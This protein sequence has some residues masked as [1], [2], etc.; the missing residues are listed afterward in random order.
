[1]LFSVQ[2]DHITQKGSQISVP[3]SQKHAPESSVVNRRDLN[4]TH[5]FAQ[6]IIENIISCRCQSGE[7]TTGG[8]HRIAAEQNGTQPPVIHNA[9][10]EGVVVAVVCQ[11]FLTQGVDGGVTDLA[12]A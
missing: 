10:V 3:C 4:I 6:R 2:F 1:M 12:E 5:G 9:L 7:Q 11:G 8:I